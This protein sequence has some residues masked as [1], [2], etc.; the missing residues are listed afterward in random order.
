MSA[1]AEAESRILDL[2]ARH[3]DALRQLSELEARLEAVL[4][5]ALPALAGLTVV[6]ALLPEPPQVE[7]A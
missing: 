3:D 5:E 6:P 7:A 1:A 4:K 2:E